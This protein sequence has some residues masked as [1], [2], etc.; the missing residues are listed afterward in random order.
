MLSRHCT[1]LIALGAQNTELQLV[2]FCAQA[3]HE[4]MQWFAGGLETSLHLELCSVY[5]PCGR[6]D[7]SFSK[8]TADELD[9][10]VG[11]DSRQRYRFLSPPTNRNRLWVLGVLSPEVRGDKECE[12][13][14]K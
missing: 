2:V 12:M 8:L 4:T 5:K 7:C 1:K 6:K 9:Y 13:F 10:L 14:I 11:F 3:R